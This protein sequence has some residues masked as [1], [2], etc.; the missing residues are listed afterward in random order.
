M[1][2]SRASLLITT[3]G[4]DEK[5]ALRALTSHKPSS[6][7]VLALYTSEDTWSRV[8]KAFSQLRVIASQLGIEAD[9]VRIDYHGEKL[10][11]LAGRVK[12]LLENYA[13]DATSIVLA[14]TGGPRILVV[15]TLLAAVALP[16]HLAEKIVLRIEG[17]GF[18]AVVTEP[19]SNVVPLP[20]DETMRRIV[21]LLLQALRE[22]RSIGPT[23]V[24]QKLGIPKSTAYK[25]LQELVALGIASYD[26]RT[27]SYQATERAYINA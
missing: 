12:R 9:I 1:H 13:R 15:A 18:E 16:R 3:L 10:S 21:N 7:R 25:R 14:L 5:F 26:P 22:G 17:E 27:R 4:F 23:E 6:L 2:S 8:M 11:V 20:L 24:S 19:L